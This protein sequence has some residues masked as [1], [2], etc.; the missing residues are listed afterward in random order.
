L[1]ASAN[2]TVR[3][4]K[5]ITKDVLFTVKCDKRNQI[6]LLVKPSLWRSFSLNIINTQKKLSGILKKTLNQNNLRIR[7]G[8]EY[9]KPVQ[10]QLILSLGEDE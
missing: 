2:V 9:K 5:V 6:Y 4:L 8:L 7:L 1:F 10:E 3:L